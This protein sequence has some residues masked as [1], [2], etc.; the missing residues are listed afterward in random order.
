[1]KGQLIVE[2]FENAT[3]TLR[4]A[5]LFCGNEDERVEM[6]VLQ[7][8]DQYLNQVRIKHE[9]ELVRLE[10]EIVEQ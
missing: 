5:I 10:E 2:Y 3:D 8:I 6:S 4:V 9:E 1:M 7:C